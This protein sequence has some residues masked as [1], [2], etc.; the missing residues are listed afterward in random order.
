MCPSASL[1]STG[2]CSYFWREK[3]P[4]NALK[5]CSGTRDEPVTNWRSRA[6]LSS[7][8]NSTAFQNHFTMLLS[9]VQCFN[10]VFA[11]QSLTSIFP[12]PQIMSCKFKIQSNISSLISINGFGACQMMSNWFCKKDR[13]YTKGKLQSL[14]NFK[15]CRNITFLFFSNLTFVHH[16]FFKWPQLKWKTTNL[17]CEFNNRSTD[18]IHVWKPCIIHIWT[19]YFFLDHC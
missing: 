9:G 10:L 2:I 11:F 17:S 14:I 4:C 8:K 6:R 15:Q 16:S 12:S 19:Q 5:P 7:S 13:F 18:S 1:P 3:L